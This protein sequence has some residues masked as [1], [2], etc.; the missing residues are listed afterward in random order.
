MAAISHESI[1]EQFSRK[2]KFA[3]ISLCNKFEKNFGE[4]ISYI[5]PKEGFLIFWEMELFNP[6]IKKSLIL[7]QK[8][9]FFY[10]RKL[11]FLAIRFQKNLAPSLKKFYIFSKQKFSYVSEENFA[12]LKKKQKAK[13]K[14][15][16]KQKQ[17][18]K[19]HTPKPF[20]IFPK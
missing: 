4:K 11:D 18:K 8:I 12:S 15:K 6:K 10:I 9:V 17:N 1:L 14:A 7:F 19:Q 3:V 13:Q 16:T 2:F 5:C 20:Y